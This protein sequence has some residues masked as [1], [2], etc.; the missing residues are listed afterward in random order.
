MKD[1]VGNRVKRKL[2]LTETVDSAGRA[3]EEA[4]GQILI[5][6]EVSRYKLTDGAIETV[7][8]GTSA[9]KL[10]EIT[11][12]KGKK[13]K[14]GTYVNNM[15]W[16]G[17]DPR[18]VTTHIEGK[19]IGEFFAKAHL[20]KS[21]FKWVENGRRDDS[22]NGPVPY[23]GP[24]GNRGLRKQTA[25]VAPHLGN[26]L[27]RWAKLVQVGP[28]QPWL[29][30][31][32]TGGGNYKEIAPGIFLPSVIYQEENDYDRNG[33]GTFIYRIDGEVTEWK[34]NQDLSADTFKPLEPE[35]SENF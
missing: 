26:A 16:A 19:S 8:D 10:Q 22:R 27:I 2:S 21:T 32:S 23:D 12:V 13:F 34:V 9:L 20:D 4:T 1:P 25:W 28:D 17:I 29:E 35:G 18:E 33:R 14:L 5:G 31:L 11:N 6:S 7:F 30:Y 15:V 3:R 24:D